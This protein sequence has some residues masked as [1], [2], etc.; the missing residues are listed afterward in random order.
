MKKL[1]LSLLALIVVAPA[2][3]A[4][5]GIA[6]EVKSEKAE[7]VSALVA[8][9]KKAPA[10]KAAACNIANKLAED[11]MIVCDKA[12]GRLVTFLDKNAPV[13]VKW[14]ISSATD[15]PCP[16]TPGCQIMHC[17]PPGGPT[18]CCHTTAPYGAC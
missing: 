12:D 2:W 1:L 11:V 15:R 18:M 13:S 7:E 4:S 10:Y 3:G 6:I 9:L 16:G 14:S 5:S 17:P 8:K